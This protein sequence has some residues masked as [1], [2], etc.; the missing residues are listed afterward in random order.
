MNIPGD[1]AAGEGNGVVSVAIESAILAFA[2]CDL[3]TDHSKVRI[4]VQPDAAKAVSFDLCRG[5]HMD[6][7]VAFG[8]SPGFDATD[9]VVADAGAV[10]VQRSGAGNVALAG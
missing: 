9:I 1:L 7:G 6:D 2:P 3:T 10:A 8:R 4:L 5:C